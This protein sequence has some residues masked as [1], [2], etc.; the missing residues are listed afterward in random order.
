MFKFLKNDF[1]IDKNLKSG[2]WIISS[3]NPYHIT[4][5]SYVDGS[6]PGVF[7]QTIFFKKSI[8]VDDNTYYSNTLT[9][10]NYSCTFSQTR[11]CKYFA[12]LE[13]SSQ[14]ART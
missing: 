3:Q 8:F 6:N 13:I 7:N 5:V 11:N 10:I 2:G 1:E 4:N 14:F 9:L 12:V